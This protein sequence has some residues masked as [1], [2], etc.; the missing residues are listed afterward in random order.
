MIPYRFTK[1]V[2]I[3]VGNNVEIFGA[4]TIQIFL[5]ILIINQSLD[6]ILEEKNHIND[7]LKWLSTKL[8]CN[9]SHSPPCE[10]VNV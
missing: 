8:K 9:I 5:Q 6:G 3:N 2:Q 1:I 10:C 7:R 4:Y